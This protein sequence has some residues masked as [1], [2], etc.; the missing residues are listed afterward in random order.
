MP[1]GEMTA[2]VPQAKASFSFPLPLQSLK[3]AYL[4][5]RLEGEEDLYKMWKSAVR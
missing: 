2:A 3:I 5:V 1:I 4:P